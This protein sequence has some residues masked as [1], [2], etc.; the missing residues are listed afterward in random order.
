ML[1]SKSLIDLWQNGLYQDRVIFSRQTRFQQIVMTRNRDDLRLYLDGHLQF[2]SRDEH[3]YHESLIHVPMMATPFHERV[4]L[5]GAG[6]GLAVRELLKYKDIREIV[7]VDIDPEMTRLARTQPLV[8]KLN[9]GALEDPRVRVVNG[10]AFG[11][12]TAPGD[13]FEVIIADLPD[14]IGPL[15]FPDPRVRRRLARHGL[16]VTQSTSA[17]ATPEAFWSIRATLEKAGFPHVTPYHAY[18]PS[19]GDWGFMLAS[20]TKLDAAG[21]KLS[22]PVRFLDTHT[23]TR[24]FH[25]SADMKPLQVKPNTLDQP[26]LLRYYLHGWQHWN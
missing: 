18:V 21:L 19:F 14:P 15:S 6:D 4:L 3:R 10:D 23:V 12:L 8:R 13:P 22:V 2:S 20:E 5:L 16:F 17:Y 24:L 1:F 11:Y 26:H 7:V 25:F 9:S